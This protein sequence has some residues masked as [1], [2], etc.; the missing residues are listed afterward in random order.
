ML[1]AD[2]IKKA[3]PE[4]A[5]G[6]NVDAK[7]PGFMGVEGDDG[8]VEGAHLKG[9]LPG[10]AGALAGLKEGDSIIEYNGKKINAWMDLVNTTRALNAGDTA[11][12]KVKRGNETL[13]L[14][15]KLGERE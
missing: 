8:G 3:L 15:V 7:K 4:L 13:E 11:R 6:K 9:V 1:Q 5:A 12:L 2:E 10:K 14:S